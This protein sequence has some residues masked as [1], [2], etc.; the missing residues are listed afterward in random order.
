MAVGIEG[1]KVVLLIRV[2]GVA[3]VVEHRDGFDDPL[4]GFRA[5]GRHAWCHDGRTAGE[6]LTQLIVQRA[7]A[8]SLRVHDWTSR[9]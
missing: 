2:V 7:N 9:L 5:E 1:P 6:M 3:K 4:N 8:R